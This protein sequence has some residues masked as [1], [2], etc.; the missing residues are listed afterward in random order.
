LRNVEFLLT[1]EN[2]NQVRNVQISKGTLYW[3]GIVNLL[4]GRYRLSEAGHPDWICHLI[5]SGP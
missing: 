5:I 3:R 4:P 1:R 2:G